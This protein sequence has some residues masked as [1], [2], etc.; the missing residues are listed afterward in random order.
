MLTNFDIRKALDT[1]VSTTGAV[2]VPEVV[3]EGIRMFVE[4]RSPLWN[5]IPKVQAERSACSFV[6]R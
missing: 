4:T 1:S 3:S 6:R 2:L 5:I